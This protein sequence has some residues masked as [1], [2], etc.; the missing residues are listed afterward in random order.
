MVNSNQ[1]LMFSQLLKEDDGVLRD[2]LS[3]SGLSEIETAATIDRFIFE[4]RHATQSDGKEFVIEGVGTMNSDETGRLIFT[5]YTKSPEE[6]QEITETPTPET[7]E[8]PEL[9]ELPEEPISPKTTIEDAVRK[10]E[11]ANANLSNKT[12]RPTTTKAKN[13]GVDKV[14]VMG[15]V[16]AIVAVA[17]IA[18]G[19]YASNIE[20]ILE[21]LNK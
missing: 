20:F 2:L 7:P 11:Q 4:L 19:L 17:A 14:L 5:P 9:P 1:E 3:D 16:A 10:I 21:L 6:P 18:Y 12:A 13:R 8:L 15:I